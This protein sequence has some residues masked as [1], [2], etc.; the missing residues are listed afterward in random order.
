M[1]GLKFH[2]ILSW[3]LAFISLLVILLCYIIT[4]RWI[5]PIELFLVLH[6]VIEWI[7]IGV[8]VIHTILST[9]YYKHKW[10]RLIKGLKSKRA[11]PIYILRLIQILSNRAIIVIVVLFAIS[12][13]TYYQWFSLGTAD[14]IPFDWYTNLDLYLSII[15]IIHVAVGTKF[16]FIRKR[17]KHWSSN[18]LIILLSGSLISGVIYLNI[19]S[20]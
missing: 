10:G 14:I 19:L 13:L 5:S 2:R 8:L 9:K 7:F 6:F 20:G 15:I 1:N 4:H 11:R 3:F 12:G 16:Y 17:I 18:L